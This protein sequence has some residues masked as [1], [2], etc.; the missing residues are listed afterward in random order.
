MVGVYSVKEE[1][2]DAHAR[3]S[4]WRKIAPIFARIFVNFRLFSL[5]SI[6]K[7]IR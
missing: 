3:M 4:T 7:I 1:A 6:R 2:S 5:D